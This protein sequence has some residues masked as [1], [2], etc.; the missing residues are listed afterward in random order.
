MS[1]FNLTNFDY[2]E[3]KKMSYKDKEELAKEIRE[4]IISSVSANGG[5]LSSNLGIVELTIALASAF[6]F[7]EDDIL[8]DVGHQTYPYKI[9]TSRDISKIRLEDGLLPFQSRKE[10]EYDKFEAGHSS[11]SISIGL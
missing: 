6:S 4:K 1:K 5:H 9:L 2:K 7:E 10:S 11:T 3:V 8:F